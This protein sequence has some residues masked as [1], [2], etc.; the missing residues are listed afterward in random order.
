MKYIAKV[1]QVLRKDIH[2]LATIED[3]EVKVIGPLPLPDRVEIELD[4]SETEPC[5][6]YRYTEDDEFCGDTWHETFEYALD[7]AAFEYGLKREDFEPVN[8]A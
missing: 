6:M 4:G 5:K 1:R 3:G 2:K 7:Q 8:D